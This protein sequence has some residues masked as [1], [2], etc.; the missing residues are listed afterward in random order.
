[1]TKKIRDSTHL[2]KTFWADCTVLREANPTADY[3]AESWNVDIR[4][5]NERNSRL[6]IQTFKA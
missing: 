3:L 6:G 4:A 1:M 2:T 5:G